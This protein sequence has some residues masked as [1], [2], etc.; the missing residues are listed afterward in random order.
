MALP[1]NLN[2]AIP[3]TADSATRV[4]EK[5]IR[6]DSGT[7]FQQNDLLRFT[8]P[9]GRYG[10]VI[11]PSCTY[12]SYKIKYVSADGT[13]VAAADKFDRISVA[14]HP[15]TVFDR[16]SV[17]AGSTLLESVRGYGTIYHNL[18]AATQPMDIGY[19][20]AALSRSEFGGGP[21]SNIG[22]DALDA[23]APGANSA[24]YPASALTQMKSPLLY[25]GHILNT[26]TPSDERVITEVLSGVIGTC[27][28]KH[29]PI[30]LTSNG[31][32]LE[33]TV[34]PDN[35]ALNVQRVGDF[36]GT[37]TTDAAAKTLNAAKTANHSFVIE[38]PILTV[39]YLELPPASMEMLAPGGVASLNTQMYTALNTANLAA[40]LSQATI[41]IPARYRSLKTLMTIFQNPA[42][43]TLTKNTHDLTHG[44]MKDW[45]YSLGSELFPLTPCQGF[46]ASYRQLLSAFDLQNY[47]AD[48]QITP[49]AWVRE[50]DGTAN[51]DRDAIGTGNNLGQPFAVYQGKFMMAVSMERFLGKS[52]LVYNGHSSIA[53]NIH[54]T[55]N[56]DPNSSTELVV[57]HIAHYDSIIS[58]A[59]GECS[60]S[61]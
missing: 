60:V 40:N 13:T 47:D 27:A 6:P 54:L 9:K 42:C 20:H 52:G 59:G 34:A 43:Y 57:T 5:Q 23:T 56:F 16:L 12:L 10:A 11:D 39:K 49:E 15:A 4:Y 30:S 44:N 1:S 37:L 3:P 28:M 14:G 41:V 50:G 7:R 46:S 26:T 21:F 48:N 45:Q 36:T 53:D 61:F 24:N 22:D 35:Q 25:S 33:L 19:V 31:L 29:F 8:L 58:I 51:L 17:F 18:A 32:A 2:F 38:D 55:I